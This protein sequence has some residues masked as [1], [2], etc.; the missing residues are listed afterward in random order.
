MSDPGLTSESP[1]QQAMELGRRVPR[2]MTS[3][4]CHSRVVTGVWVE[5]HRGAIR[6]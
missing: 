2:L 4:Y 6:R 1:V 5:Y 3:S